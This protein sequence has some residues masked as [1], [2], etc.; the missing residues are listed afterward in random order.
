MAQVRSKTLKTKL[1]VLQALLLIKKKKQRKRYVWSKNYLLRRKSKSSF[2]CI[3]KELKCESDFFNYTWVG[4][5][6]FYD[7]LN[8]IE[9]K[10]KKEDTVMRESISPGARLE[11]TLRF[12]ASGQSLT[13]L[14]YSSR[15]SLSSL[16]AIIP[17]TCQAIY[18]ELKNDYLKVSF[19]INPICAYSSISLTFS[20]LLF[21]L[22]LGFNMESWVKRRWILRGELSQ[23][24]S[25]ATNY[26][27]KK[28]VVRSFSYVST[29]TVNL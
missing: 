27:K 6:H 17:E 29:D 11:T 2:T 9:G 12:L 1:L 19:I 10:I 23:F 15:I 3:F 18:D 20:S 14:Q 21:K 5:G 22:K 24:A 28:N 26:T 25:Y 8:R 13:S 16:S 7:I 4:V